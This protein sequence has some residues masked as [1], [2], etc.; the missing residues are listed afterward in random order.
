VKF[1]ELAATERF[2][3][4]EQLGASARFA[5]ESAR[6]EA[7]IAAGEADLKIAELVGPNRPSRCRA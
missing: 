6:F 2:F 7:M 3:D 1:R 4:L 5:F